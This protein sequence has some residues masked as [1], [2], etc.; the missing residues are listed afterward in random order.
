[1]NRSIKLSV[2]LLGLYFTNPLVAESKLSEIVVSPSQR[3][4]TIFDSLNSVEVITQEQI[5]SFG[6]TTVDEILSHSSSISIGSN[7]GHGQTKSIF[8][9]GTESNHTKVLIN[10]VALNPGTLGVASI[11]HI[12]VEMLDRIEIS[13]GSMSTLYGRDTIGGVINIITKKN[14]NDDKTQVFIST[15]RDETNKIGFNK[16]F[17]YNSHLLSIN[18]MNINT[19]GY[20][21]KTSSTKNHG[22]ENDNL[23]ID[24]SY[25]YN[26]NLFELNFYQSDGNTEYDSFGSNLNQ[27]HKDYHTKLTWNKNYI[28][29]KYRLVFIDKENKIDQ[30]SASATDY[31]HTKINEVTLEKNYYDLFNTNTILG[32]TYTDEALY[33][34]SYG[35][36][37]RKSNSIREYY[38]Q[39]E[40]MLN[41]SLINIG[42][43]HI[44]HGLYGNFL[45]GNF[46]IGYPL[47]KKIKLIAGIGKSFRSPDGTD[48]YGYGGNANLEPEESTTRELSMKYKMNE[49]D[50]FIASIFSNSITNLIE[51]DGSM[52]QNI[53]RSKIQGIEI[54]Y[55][56]VYDKLNY[57]FDYSFIK[58]DDLT[59]NVE[60]SRRPENKIV[61]KVSYRYD[62]RN[63]IGVSLIGATKSDNSIYDSHTLG[64]H[65]RINMTYLYNHSN[66][67]IQ[68]KMNNIFDKKYRKAHN[69][70]SEGKSYYISLMRN[71]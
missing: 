71:F 49:N 69:Y 48:L 65:T 66:Y 68:L 30:A 34:L 54:G 1:M 9:R 36:T 62:Q 13:K 47:N 20:K 6:Y 22:Y 7:G 17:S 63:N 33:E 16:S 10:G 2:F 55:Y 39:S 18:Y 25:S 70:N 26:N 67:A 31:T 24:Y 12:S 38:F 45:T 41:N 57:T 37:F 4:T 23:N 60:L 8:M 42:A 43:R 50:G 56:G 51:S 27:D 14:Y 52:M 35:T 53:N 58:A 40:Y 5:Q 15:G 59:N 64:G 32:A 28:N 61:A 3:P 29:S 11:Q 19:D 44:N 46:N 21:A